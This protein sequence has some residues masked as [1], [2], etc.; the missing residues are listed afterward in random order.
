[1]NVPDECYSNLLTMNVPD[2]CYSN[3][4]TMNVPDECYTGLGILTDFF[5][6]V[7]YGDNIK[8]CLATGY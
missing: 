7:T 2:E 6:I 3:L 4:L 1:M 5:P 8:T